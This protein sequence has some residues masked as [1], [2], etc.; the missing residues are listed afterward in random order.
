[1]IEEERKFREEQLKLIKEERDRIKCPEEVG[2][3]KECR[4]GY[5]EE[6]DRLCAKRMSNGRKIPSPC[7]MFMAKDKELRDCYLLH[8]CPNEEFRDCEHRERQWFC[9]HVRYGGMEPTIDCVSYKKRGK[10]RSNPKDYV[11]I[12]M[13]AGD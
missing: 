7:N 8:R 4:H 10:P 6:G 11:D 12:T 3:W 9:S 1:M 5:K 13:Y 2:V